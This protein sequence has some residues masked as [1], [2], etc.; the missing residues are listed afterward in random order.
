MF[1]FHGWADIH[2]CF[3]RITHGHCSIFQN[4]SGTQERG[5]KGCKIQTIPVDQGPSL[6]QNSVPS[7]L[8]RFRRNIFAWLCEDVRRQS[9]L[10]VSVFLVLT[11][12]IS[13]T[14]FN[15][16]GLKL[17]NHFVAGDGSYCKGLISLIFGALHEHVNIFI[18]LTKTLWVLLFG[19][20]LHSHYV[21]FT[22]VLR[23]YRCRKANLLLVVCFW[24]TFYP[25]RNQ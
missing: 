19:S 17:P 18:Y 4:H 7:A 10:F 21:S 20:I 23:A 9:I 13:R 2:T 11:K 24:T 25:E 12:T 3:I 15:E 8:W 6:L 5:L 1:I 14:K 16:S 22:N